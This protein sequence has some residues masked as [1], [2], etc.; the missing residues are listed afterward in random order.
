MLPGGMT[1]S[2]HTILLAS[3][4]SLL[5]ACAPA[6]DAA[7]EQTMFHQFP[8]IPIEA[9]YETDDLCQAWTLHNEETLY[10]ST[11]EMT[12]T[13][14]FHHSNW[15]F[16]PESKFGEDG[17][18]N[19][20]ER[21]FNELTAAVTG[22][23]LFAQS[24]QA[25]SE[26]QQFVPG[27][28]IVVPP[29]S[30]VVGGLHLLN[31]T[32][33]EIDASISLN[34]H[35]IPEDQVEARLAPL[36][37]T[38]NTLDI[39]PLAKSRFTG[40]CDVSAAYGGQLDFSIYYVLPHYHI[41]GTGMGFSALRDGQEQILFDDQSPIGTPLGKIMDPPISVDGATQLRFSCDYTNPRDTS[42][43]TGIGD[44]EMC[45]ILAFTD[46]PMTFGGGVL[47][48]NAVVGT[49]ADGRVLN[50]GDCSVVAVPAPG[51]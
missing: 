6:E 22:G 43:G 37:L 47:D 5:G 49:D 19:C 38:Y 41:L 7:G 29:H 46:A 39:P 27:A 1:S 26:V 12:A 18:F 24:T 51:S 10:V 8:E 28:A 36:A 32:G 3:G 44:Q 15:Y 13:P 20:E 30:K 50:E 2:R 31:A 4:L 23:V 11:V 21:G 45:I 17:T 35:T 14:G 25:T 40:T 48:S 9:A 33:N 42:V 16:A 34:L